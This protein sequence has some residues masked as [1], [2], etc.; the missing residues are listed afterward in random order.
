MNPDR[1]RR[2][3]D[4]FERLID[5]PPAE[6]W[7]RLHDLCRGDDE[8]A[9]EVWPLI[10][11][12]A[13]TPG[14]LR[15]GAADLASALLESGGDAALPRP[16][17][18]YVIREYLGEGGAGA[19]YL[20]DRDDLRMTVAVKVLHDSWAS[21]VRRERFA[22]EQRT[23]A[24]LDHRHIARILDAGVTEG[25]PWFAMEYVEGSRITDYCNARGLDL[26]QRLK[27]FRA[28][29]EAVSFAHRN[30][31]VHLDLKPAN[32][33]VNQTG[34]VKLVDF[35]I[36]RHLTEAGGAAE[37]TM[38][39]HRVLSLNYASPEQIRGEAVDVQTDVH[40]LGIV[41]Y[42]LVAG[43]PPIDLAAVS[44]AA[45]L[46]RLHETPRRPSAAELERPLLSVRASRAE[47]RDLDALCLTAI[48]RD[49]TARY[50]TV[51]R[52]IRDVDH[53]LSNQPLEA[54]TG[55]L[56]PYRI[57]KFL[58]RHRRGVAVTAAVLI[59]LAAT[60]AFFTVRLID[61][62]DRA[63]DSEARMQRIHRL[64][65]NLFEGDDSVA[66]PAD[67]LRVVSLLDR[68]VR[69]AD[70]LETERDLQADLRHTLGGLYHKLGHFDRAEPLL[71]AALTGWQAALGD[72]DPRTVR[73][74]LAL[75]SLRVDQGEL[76]DA[77]RLVNEAL[78]AARHRRTVDA[79]EVAT[80]TAALGKVLVTAGDY[81][82]SVPLLEESV[83]A[84]STGRVS[85]ELS[86]ALGDLANAQYYLGHV[87]ASEATNLR[88]LALDRELFGNRHPHVAV[89]HYNLGNIRLDR[90]DY[91]G[92]ERLFRQALQI[93]EAWYGAEHP[94]TA[95][96]LLMVGRSLA[97]QGR[98]DEAAS[99]YERAGEVMRRT[100]GERHLRFGFVLSLS[101][102]LARDQGSLD[103]AEQLFERAAAIFKSA[104]GEQHE[105][106]LHQLSNLGSVGLA[107]KE[108]ADAE[109][110]LRAAA[111]GLGTVVPDQRYTA[112]AQIRLGAALA[113]LERHAEAEQPLRAGY[114]LLQKLSPHDPEL[115]F[116]RRQLIVV[117]SALNKPAEAEAIR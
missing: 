104:L 86:E 44:P 45:L 60:S 13:A 37:K 95:S 71:E 43:T 83:R 93:H 23:L 102:D 58:V 113:G 108:Y 100:Y 24:S 101:G 4:L 109:K 65:L 117:Y 103:R 111:R 114:R 76:D 17:G 19:V 41:L 90:G 33:L 97:Y 6:R 74:R 31:I 82:A 39:A 92:G 61:A 91:P 11:A 5:E 25:R 9:A 28:V 115:Q 18:Q 49:K 42:E 99:L 34:E 110:L 94:K 106:Y 75:V 16:F 51:D 29:C 50:E 14:I 10:E 53:F 64:M 56:Q 3:E 69:E 72:A 59:L 85:A 8:L 77:K 84:L 81:G 78:E 116:A 12:D 30:L 26:R 52:L 22:S 21:P 62:R 96:T 35:G 46:Q 38:T 27:L 112:M 105:F 2:I 67:H 7:Q 48:H 1:A 54:R 57:R 89:D 80:A 40:A 70:S 107:R 55:R 32:I 88:S 68:G 66:G 87:D 47:W 63:L 98:L 73:A 36:A 20:A 79:V 15:Q